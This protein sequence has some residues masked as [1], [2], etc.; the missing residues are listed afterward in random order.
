MMI[1]HI[2]NSVIELKN[3]AVVHYAL[4][5]VC[6]K[7]AVEWCLYLFAGDIEIIWHCKCDCNTIV[8]ICSVV[9]DH[10]EKKK[11]VF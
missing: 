6:I 2:W 11:L 3:H 5:T 10:L 7:M 9:D 4:I 1:L 8:K